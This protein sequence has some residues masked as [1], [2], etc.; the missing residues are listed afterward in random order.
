MPRPVACE[1]EGRSS[2]ASP[3]P[4][5]RVALV[6]LSSHRSRSRL[7]PLVVS[8]LPPPRPIALALRRPFIAP[9]RRVPLSR[10]LHRVAF[11]TPG[12]LLAGL[13]RLVGY[14]R[15]GTRMIVQVGAVRH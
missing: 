9:P 10:R 2:V 11:A 3:S 1:H 14:P 5:R 8:P 6:A 15:R 4:F 7:R 13:P 12:H